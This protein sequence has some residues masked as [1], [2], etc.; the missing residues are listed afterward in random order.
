MVMA[1]LTGGEAEQ[2][3][4]AMGATFCGQGAG[5]GINRSFR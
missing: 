2:L 3:R 4:R 5:H 1:D